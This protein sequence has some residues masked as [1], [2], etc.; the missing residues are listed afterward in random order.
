MPYGRP[1][2]LVGGV[3]MRTQPGG[4]ISVQPDAANPAPMPSQSFAAGSGQTVT[5]GLQGAQTSQPR[6]V[7]PTI[8]LINAGLRQPQGGQPGLG[9][10]NLS[11][12]GGIAGVASKFEG[13]GIKVYGDRTKY[14]EWEFIYDVRK[15]PSTAPGRVVP[16]AATSMGGQTRAT[17]SRR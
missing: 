13:A 11:I 16:G 12:G 4:G 3:T 8:A 17:G 1:G 5:L 6:T 7:D 9:R 14:N 15:D 10:G 2:T